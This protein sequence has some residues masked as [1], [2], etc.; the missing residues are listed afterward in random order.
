[1][2]LWRHIYE[3]FNP[4]AVQIGPVGIHW[5]GIMYML[6]LLSAFWVAKRIIR[7]DALDI[8]E[9]TIDSF[10]LW[11]TIGVILGARL[12]YIVFYDPH[13]FWYL[14]YPW[15]I[16]NPFAGGEYVGIRGFSYH[17]GLVG[18]L[19]ALVLFTR[20]RKVPFLPLLDLSAVAAPAGYT[21]G[22]I[23]NFL[24]QELVGRAT[25]V[26]WGIYVDGVLRHPSQLYEA[27]SEGLTI[28]IVLWLWRRRKRFDGE[29]AMIYG[30]LYGLTRFA[31]EF[32]REPDRQLGYLA[33]GWLTMGQILSAII[34]VVSMAGYA[35]LRRRGQP[36]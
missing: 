7:R 3:H 14:L 28:F 15:E 27:L 16:F 10:A 25:D 4:V 8:A 12:A 5:Y 32:F 18:F 21:F 26:P 1:M 22:R 35:L 30:I 29:L 34:V 20:T 24:N 9:S 36:A 13:T 19:V 11:E 33:A 23:G 31:C 2:E 6:A 17:G